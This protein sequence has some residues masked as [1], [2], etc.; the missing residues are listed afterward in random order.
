ML[1]LLA[2]ID[3]KEGDVSKAVEDGGDWIE[4]TKKRKNREEKMILEKVSDE[5]GKN[6]QEEIE[7]FLGKQSSFSRTG[8]Q[9]QSERKLKPNPMF[10]CDQCGCKLQSKE[11]LTAHTDTHEVSHLF[12][13]DFCDKSFVSDSHLEE[14]VLSEHTKTKNNCDKRDN[15]FKNITQPEKHDENVY[16]QNQ[17]DEW[18]CNGCAFQASGV[19]ELINHLK[20]TGHQP[21]K[22]I[23]LKTFF[24]EYKQCYTCKME[25]D[26]YYKLMSHRKDVHP[27]KK[28]CRNPPQSCPW[29]KTCWYVH[30][31][32]PMDVDQN[33][34]NTTPS[35]STFNCSSCGEVIEG[36]NNF[37]THKKTKHSD[38]ILPCENYLKGSCGR[39]EETCWFKHSPIEVAYKATNQQQNPVF[40]EAHPNAFPPD[41]M[42]EMKK[43]MNS[44]YKKIIEHVDIKFQAILK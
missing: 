43:M 40:P 20:I 10:T 28:K 32:E 33:S 24:N 3:N 35:S 18:N 29:G 21:S 9:N 14:H 25:F 34:V 5:G 22:Y 6:C 7:L 26:G 23:E 42:S 41:Q 11:L 13:C 15:T 4:V 8:P 39:N 44:L 37:M 27:S 30:Q 16:K 1:G 17:V 2:G 31:D 12:K 19:N 38:T 36:R